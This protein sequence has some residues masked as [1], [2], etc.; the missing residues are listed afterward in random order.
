MLLRHCDGSR[1]DRRAKQWHAYIEK[2]ASFWARLL[3]K[4]T[5]REIASGERI[6][7]MKTSIGDLEEPAAV[8][9]A[10]ALRAHRPPVR[11]DSGQRLLADGLA[12]GC[13]LRK[14]AEPP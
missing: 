5:A 1:P 14:R 9:I 8:E 7:G 13:A 12:R 3:C 11:A 4:K 2:F 6:Y 10:K